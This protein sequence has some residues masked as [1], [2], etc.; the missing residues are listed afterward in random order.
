V[1]GEIA[2]SAASENKQQGTTGQAMNRLM[3]PEASKQ[4]ANRGRLLVHNHGVQPVIQQQLGDLRPALEPSAMQWGVAVFFLINATTKPPN[5]IQLPEALS[6]SEKRYPD[7][8]V[9][10]H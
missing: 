1:H 7:G 6:G 9:C 2:V 5:M 4:G 10:T 3:R 8:G